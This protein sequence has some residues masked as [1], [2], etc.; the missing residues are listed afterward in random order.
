MSNSNTQYDLPQSLQQVDLN[1]IKFS[2]ACTILLLSAGFI[3]DSWVLVA[4]AAICQLLG[5]TGAQYAP[6]CFLYDNVAKRMGL[7]KPNVKPD[8]SQPH[9]FASFVGGAMDV[10]GFA[11]L[12]AGSAA[13]WI[14]VAIVFVLANLNLWISFCAGCMMYYQ[15]NRL[16]MPGFTAS[17]QALRGDHG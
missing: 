16:G 11:L 17:R 6:Y 2:Q 13:G 10:I 15:L 9:H 8:F 12:A 7:V 14:F 4:I 1:V 3:V 5:A